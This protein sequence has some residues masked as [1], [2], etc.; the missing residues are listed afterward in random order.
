MIDDYDNKA[1]SIFSA[2]NWGDK[3]AGKWGEEF[4]RE[5]GKEEL[6]DSWFCI[7]DYEDWFKGRFIDRV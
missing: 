7:K 3:D 2:Y 6:F 1:F 5:E 4:K